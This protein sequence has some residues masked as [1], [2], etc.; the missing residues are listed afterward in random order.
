MNENLTEIIFVLDKSGSMHSLT[1]DTIGGVNAFIKEQKELTSFDCKLTMVQ[2]GSDYK[3]VCSSTSIENVKDLTAEDYVADG[4]CTKLYDAIGRAI[5]DAGHRFRSMDEKDRPGKVLFVVLTDGLENASKEYSKATIEQMIK[6]QTDEFN[7]TF[8]YLGANQDAFQV[9]TSL[10]ITGSNTMTFIPT[11]NGLD[12]TYKTL[13]R[14]TVAYRC[15]ASAGA[16][17]KDFIKEEDRKEQKAEG[18]LA[19]STTD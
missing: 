7:W 15:C 8:V 10:G 5:A 3:I 2:F 6:T 14:R 11:G 16:P 19:S 12:L 1:S 18:E 9:G 13:A 4:N 17:T